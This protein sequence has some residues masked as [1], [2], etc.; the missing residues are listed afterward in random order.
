MIDVLSPSSIPLSF[1]SPHPSSLSKHLL[2]FN[3]TSLSHS[4]SHTSFFCTLCLS[5]RKGA[6]CTALEGCG[7]GAVFCKGCLKD[8]FSLLI[9][10]GD[11]ETVGCPCLVCVKARGGKGEKVVMAAQ[12]L[13]GIVGEELTARFAHLVEKRRIDNDPSYTT[14]PRPACQASVPPP[15]SLAASNSESTLSARLSDLLRVCPACTYAFCVLCSTAYHAL[16]PC[17]T[18][19]STRLIAAYLSGSPSEQQAL[20]RKYGKGNVKRLVDA[21][22]EERQNNEWRLAHTISCPTCGVGVERSAGCSHMTCSR[23]SGHFCFRCGITLSGI[24]PYVSPLSKSSTDQICSYS[25]YSDPSSGSK[26]YQK[27]FDFLPG[28]EPP[29]EEWLGAVLADEH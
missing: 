14:C 25:H 13:R 9:A 5:H 10:E 16:N 24:D 18:S 17:P 20:E 11:T 12:E 28:N 27:L 23:C 4:F 2:D 19:H 29:I 6:H 21:A 22:E 15:T 1:A 8:F 7:S 26:C 3:Q